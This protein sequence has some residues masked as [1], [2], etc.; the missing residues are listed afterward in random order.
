[1]KKIFIGLLLLLPVV[2][3]AQAWKNFNQADILFTAKYPGNWINKIKEGKRV[4]FT[5]PA[6]SENDDFRQNINVSVTSNPQYRN[7]LK[8]KDVIQEIIDQVKL[9]F[10]EFNEE[11]R[12]PMKWNGVDAYEITYTGTSKTGDATPVRIV[13]RICFY[14]SRLYLT[15]YTCLME[16]DAYAVIAKKIIDSIKFN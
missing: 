11:S 3:L 1:M 15:T 5:S 13:Q 10:D 14:K 8:I 4:F 6:E 12:K 2:S 16:K 7:E 9:S